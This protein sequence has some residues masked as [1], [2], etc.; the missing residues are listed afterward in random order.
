LWKKSNC[1]TLFFVA[2]GLIIALRWLHALVLDLDVIF[3]TFL[4]HCGFGS[5]SSIFTILIIAVTAHYLIP[6]FG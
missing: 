2:A 4:L 5:K 1:R 6:G 3:I